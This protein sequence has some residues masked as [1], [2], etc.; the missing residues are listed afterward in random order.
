ME[1]KVH[2]IVLLCIFVNKIVLINHHGLKLAEYP[3]DQITFCGMCTDDK[4]FFGLVTTRKEEKDPDD[5]GGEEA[6]GPGGD[7]NSSIFFSSCHVFMTEPVSDKEEV[8]RRAKAFQFDP[9][10]E[11]DGSS[12]KCKEF[13]LNADPIIRV[14]MNLY[15]NR[16]QQQQ[17][18]QNGEGGQAGAA[19][20]PPA[21]IGGLSPV[22]SNSDS[23]IGF[24]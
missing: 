12:D 20:A 16:H 14:V 1:K 21:Q 17:Q 9:T 3:A 6:V 23:G 4:R 13:P 22:S 7:R 11:E 10:F 19:A 2:T 24:R 5:E 18:Q 8:E 15:G